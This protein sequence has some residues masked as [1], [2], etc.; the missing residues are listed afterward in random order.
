MKIG[1]IRYLSYRDLTVKMVGL[2]SMTVRRGVGEKDG[3]GEEKA[4]C[5]V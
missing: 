5:T 1:V 4:M 2:G 3:R